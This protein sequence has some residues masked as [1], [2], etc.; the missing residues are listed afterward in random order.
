[1]PVQRWVTASDATRL[2]GVR[3]AVVAYAATHGVQ[4]AV[5]AD[6]AIAV[7]EVLTNVAL[8]G[9]P[10]DAVTTTAECEDGE[11]VVVIDGAG[12]GLSARVDAPAVRLGL[13]IAAAL[14]GTIRVCPGARGGREISMRFPMPAEDRLNG[15]RADPRRAGEAP[16]PTP[17]PIPPA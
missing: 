14:T 2:A 12:F 16:P 9:R 1:V 15:S 10:T 5:L 4:G 3:R 6:L 13:V 8:H 11:L 7:S 17:A